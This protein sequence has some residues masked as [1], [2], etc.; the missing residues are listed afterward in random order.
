MGNFNKLSLIILMIYGFAFNIF[1]QGTWP[2]DTAGI[3][4][5]N[6]DTTI[7]G[8][9]ASVLF[10]ADFAP[11]KETTDYL[12]LDIPFNPSDYE[13]LGLPIGL[14]Y[15]LGD[16]VPAEEPVVMGFPFCFYGT[17]YSEYYACTNG[18]ISFS[19]IFANQASDF[20]PNPHPDNSASAPI[21]AIMFPFKDWY[22]GVTGGVNMYY[23]DTGVAPFRSRVL[24]FYNSP[25]FQCTSIDGTFQVVL[26]E[27]T[28]IIENHLIDVNSCPTWVGGVGTQ[29]IV[30][31]DPDEFI[32]HSGRNCTVFDANNESMHYLPNGDD[33]YTITWYKD[34]VAL[35]NSNNYQMNISGFGNGNYTITV[36]ISYGCSG[37]FFE[38]SV[39][40]TATLPNVVW[41]V[42]GDQ[43][44]DSAPIDL[45]TL[46]P[47]DGQWT[48]AGVENTIF[49]PSVQGIGVYEVCYT[50]C[51]LP[52]CQ[53]IEVINLDL[54][55]TGL[56]VQCVTDPAIDLT[57]IFSTG[58]W[59]INGVV[60]STFD[61]A[62]LGEGDYQVC[63]SECGNEFCNEVQV[64]SQPSI[65]FVSVPPVCESES[66]FLLPQ[67]LSANT[68]TN[69][70]WSGT[71]VSN[72]TLY[73][74]NTIDGAVTY[75]LS[76]G[77]CPVSTANTIVN[78]DVLPDATW[79]VDV[80][81]GICKGTLDLNEYVTYPA[82]SVWSGSG[83]SAQGI[84]NLSSLGVGSFQI[85]RTIS[86]GEC[87]NS[88]TSNVEIVDCG[89]YALPTAFTP[90]GDQ[91]NDIF[92]IEQNSAFTVNVFRVFN[93]WGTLV[94][95]SND[96]EYGWDG[97]YK[98][99]MQDI[100]TYTYHVVL[101]NTEGIKSES[102][103]NFVLLR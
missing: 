77:S 86:V 72:D 74:A 64:E 84:L 44:L 6:G 20:V 82:N 18:W 12:N 45:T 33:D 15:V 79:I 69:G 53:N 85:T 49:D 29:G 42:P 48:I 9:G 28:N 65:E 101:T 11:L 39:V 89:G 62:I 4:I 96:I 97:T 100:G 38:D 83:V 46:N 25:M 43:C 58:V 68:G 75:N 5:L 71:G 55:W 57:S 76:I 34:G 21:N 63:Y 41:Q 78:I 24:T 37:N 94:F 50:D 23:Y 8:G 19:E 61:P 54:T 80:P 98:G 32:I 47:G 60:Q 73:L 36:R 51:G 87:T 13:V 2:L 92:K 66:I 31:P 67:L 30:S 81:Q 35:A 1:G 26:F 90:N 88:H 93:R 27:T 70:T 91:I 17:S 52:A 95:Q 3:H 10:T 102:K 56:D 16:D 7:C 59:T 103:G 22:P 14:S 99:V 40:V